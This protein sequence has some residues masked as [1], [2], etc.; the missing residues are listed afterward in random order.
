MLRQPPSLYATVATPVCCLWKIS[1]TSDS[2]SWCFASQLRHR[3]ASAH[4]PSH[5]LLDRR[6]GARNRKHN[7]HRNTGARTN[8]RLTISCSKL[9][10]SKSLPQNEKVSDHGFSFRRRRSR[11]SNPAAQQQRLDMERPSFKLNF[12]RATSA[13]VLELRAACGFAR[14]CGT[15]VDRVSRV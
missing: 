10:R 14:R 12:E 13:V 6:L 4:R 3:H 11:R 15:N 9:S 2:E 5:Q 8:S 7:Y 1:Q